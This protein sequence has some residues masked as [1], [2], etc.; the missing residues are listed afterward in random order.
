ML[1]N[2]QVA[3]L[4]ENPDIPIAKNSAISYE[5]MIQVA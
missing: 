3:K 5:L 4:P 2:S 1:F